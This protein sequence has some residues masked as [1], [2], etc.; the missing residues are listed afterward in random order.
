MMSERKPMSRVAVLREIVELID[1]CIDKE[2]PFFV[3]MRASV[4]TA[5][6]PYQRTS[7]DEIRLER[8]HTRKEP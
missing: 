2:Q 3:K 8:G 5:L 1:C 4:E 6:V 7:D